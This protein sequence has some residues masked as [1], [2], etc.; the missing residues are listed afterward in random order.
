MIS[1]FCF[2]F[3]HNSFRFLSMM[4]CLYGKQFRGVQNQRHPLGVPLTYFRSSICVA[5]SVSSVKRGGIPVSTRLCYVCQVYSRGKEIYFLLY[6]PFGGGG[7]HGSGYEEDELIGN[8]RCNNLSVYIYRHYDILIAL[9]KILPKKYHFL[10]KAR[11]RVDIQRKQYIYIYIFSRYV[12]PLYS[13]V[14]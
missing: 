5:T 4:V 13:L 6:S 3:L 9:G 12:V 14:S 10:A 7:R 2:L 11:L 1:T 8:H